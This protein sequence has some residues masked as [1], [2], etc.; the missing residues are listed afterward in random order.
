M[1][2]AWLY[3]SEIT[4]QLAL[5]LMVLGIPIALIGSTMGQ[6]YYGEI[7]KNR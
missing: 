7:A 4:G 5:S 3:D 1:F 2:V 6:A